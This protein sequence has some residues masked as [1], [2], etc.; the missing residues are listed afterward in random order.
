MLVRVLNTMAC[1]FADADMP[2]LYVAAF[3]LLIHATAALMR[4]MFDAATHTRRV[5]YD[6]MAWDIAER[7]R[8]T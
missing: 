6:A 7:W 2:N 3:Q 1:L 5:K 8:L 4:I